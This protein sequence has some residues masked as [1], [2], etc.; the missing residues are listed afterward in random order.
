MSEG[1]IWQLLSLEDWIRA[2]GNLITLRFPFFDILDDE[3]EGSLRVGYIGNRG[4]L[5]TV[6]RE[7]D[8]RLWTRAPGIRKGG[9]LRVGFSLWPG[10]NIT[11][12]EE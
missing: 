7:S 5:A 2:N 12:W 11:G 9:H 3:R 1:G 10:K 6:K 4:V 8:S